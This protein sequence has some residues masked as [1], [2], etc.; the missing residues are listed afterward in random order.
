MLFGVSGALLIGITALLAGYP[1]PTAAGAV[2]YAG[3]AVAFAAAHRCRSRIPLWLLGITALVVVAGELF[4]PGQR[5]AIDGVRLGEGPQWIA[6][7]VE[8]W[9]RLL[10]WSCVFLLPRPVLVAA[11]GTALCLIRD[12]PAGLLA[13]GVPGHVFTTALAVFLL[14]RRG[15]VLPV[16]VVAGGMIAAGIEARVISVGT[17][18]EIHLALWPAYLALA[19]VAGGLEALTRRTFRKA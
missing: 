6:G 5:I 15:L 9:P 12:A 7:M 14:V 11:V 8:S 10:L 4:A 1:L 3:L 13:W 18:T 2:G 19:A 16:L 17:P